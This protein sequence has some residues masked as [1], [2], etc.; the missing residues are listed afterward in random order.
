MNLIL[1]LA[2]KDQ[3]T[4]GKDVDSNNR[5]PVKMTWMVKTV[6]LIRHLAREDKEP[7][8]MEITEVV[9]NAIGAMATKMLGAMSQA[10]A[11]EIA[12]VVVN[13]TEAMV[14]MTS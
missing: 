10:V 13:A 6:N 1:H 9:M 4:K 11:M 14:T 7:V 3:E 8:A 2:W 5:E 12:E